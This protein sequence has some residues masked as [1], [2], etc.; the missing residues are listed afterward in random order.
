MNIVF[1]FYILCDVLYWNV[2]SDFEIKKMR[3]ACQF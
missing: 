1:V 2:K 3:R